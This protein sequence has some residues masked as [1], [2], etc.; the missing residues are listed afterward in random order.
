M[1][2]LNTRDRYGNTSFNTGLGEV[3]EYLQYKK[4][5]VQ[6]CVQAKKTV[7]QDIVCNPNIGASTTVTGIRLNSN[8]WVDPQSIRL[9]FN[10]NLTGDGTMPTNVKFHDDCGINGIIKNIRVNGAGGGKNLEVIANYNLLQKIQ[11]SVSVS[12]DWKQAQGAVMEGFGSYLSSTTGSGT[13]TS[14]SSIVNGPPLVANGALATNCY[15]IALWTG[16]LGQC[17]RLLPNMLLQLSFEIDTAPLLDFVLFDSHITGYQINGLYIVYTEYIVSDLY[18]QVFQETVSTK[19][20]SLDYQ[21][22]FNNQVQVPAN[23]T[24]ISATIN[25][26]AKQLLSAYAV[27]RPSDIA[28]ANY[29]QGTVAAGA[30]AVPLPVAFIAQTAVGAASNLETIA[31]SKVSGVQWKIGTTNYPEYIMTKYTDMYQFSL[32]AM[33]RANSLQLD[34]PLNYNKFVGNARCFW[35]GVDFEN[36]KSSDNS[37]YSGINTSGHAIQLNVS[38]TDVLGSPVDAGVRVPT[39]PYPMGVVNAAGFAANSYCAGSNGGTPNSF[40]IV[41]FF[42]L[43]SRILSISPAGLIIDY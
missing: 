7:K 8:N 23:N 11:Y 38:L 6:N 37:Q 30:A 34:M 27:I 12:N 25:D 20:I 28:T 24:V 32:Q 40:F 14:A 39:V 35:L 41:D 43:H 15:S 16:M 26:S 4:K 17:P 42:L 5:T 36:S 29:G 22:F 9:G 19:G 1:E 33:N 3:P 2:L 10:F 18:R 13:I 31:G 21:T